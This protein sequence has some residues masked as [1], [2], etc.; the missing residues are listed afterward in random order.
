M[1]QVIHKISIMMGIGTAH[2]IFQIAALFH[3]LLELWNDQIVAALTITAATHAVIHFFTAVQAEHHIA[4]FLITKVHDLFIQQHTIGGQSKTEILVVDLFLFSSVSH[5]LLHHFPVH[6]RLAAK[7]VHFQIVPAAGIRNQKIQRLLTHFIAHDAAITM[8]L[9]FLGKTV[10]TSQITI[11][12]HMKA[13]CLHHRLTLL[14]IPGNI[15]KQI[16][17]KEFSLLL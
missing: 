4:H 17:R 6:Q 1:Q 7:K 2:V 9:A 13:K 15:G 10:L 3:H 12:S 5:Q 14:K 11:M 8:V 16:L